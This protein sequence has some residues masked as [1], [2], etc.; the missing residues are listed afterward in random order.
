MASSSYSILPNAKRLFYNKFN[1]KATLRYPHVT[2]LR[3]PLSEQQLNRG[4]KYRR[5]EMEKA[6]KEATSKYGYNQ[7][8]YYG[9]SEI[10]ATIEAELKQMLLWLDSNNI[11]YSVNSV[12]WYE[13][14]DTDR[15]TIYT[16]EQ[17]LVDEFFK[18]EGAGK[19]LTYSIQNPYE[20]KQIQ[21]KYK[22]RLFLKHASVDE[23]TKKA[24]LSFA[25]N[26]SDI[27]N[28]SKTTTK[29]LK[30]TREMCQPNFFIDIADE[31]AIT[32]LAM[33]APELLGKKYN[34]VN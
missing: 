29:F 28:I 23:H 6:N 34:I 19:E 31:K 7:M 21:S 24:I 12:G 2:L 9:V 25:K 22:Y 4:I 30:S 27:V 1:I 15:I 14:R 3:R 18:F 26:N 5:K 11:R 10:T 16:N 20:I 8:L 32:F 13:T 33:I 17:A